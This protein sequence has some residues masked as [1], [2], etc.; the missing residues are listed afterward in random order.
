MLVSYAY[1]E[2]FFSM[3]LFFLIISFFLQSANMHTY[4]RT[5]VYYRND[6][7]LTQNLQ[8]LNYCLTWGVPV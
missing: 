8:G 5:Y 3:L 6:F 2:F 1:N 7:N 4:V